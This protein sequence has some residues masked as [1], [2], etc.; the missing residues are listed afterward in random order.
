MWKC[1]PYFGGINFLTRQ[2]L[3]R[4]ISGPQYERQGG[5]VAEKENPG[6]S[7][8]TTDEVGG[9]V[10]GVRVTLNRRLFIQFLAFGGCS[11]TGVLLNQFESSDIPAA[12]YED[13]N[14]SGGIGIVVVFEDP[15]HFLTRL[16]PFLAR[17]EFKDLLPKP[18]LTMFGRTYAVG[19]EK[20]LE[21]SLLRKPLER[22]GSPDSR[23][24]IWY[25]LRRKG[26]YERLTDHEQHEIQM[27]HMRVARSYG[28][29]GYVSDI[30]LACHGLGKQDNDFIV[31]LLG[32]EL[33]PLSMIIQEMRKSRQTSAYLER[34]GPF[35][36]GRTVGYYFPDIGNNQ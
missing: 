20:N 4:N 19:Y 7:Q 29:K 16:R 36:V 28:R 32:S 26:K 24:A 25:P 35:F 27:E 13:I 8:I 21:Y 18:E 11:D 23:W 5:A 3:G 2:I 14:D 31:G 12:V 17:P 34:L 22:L 10:E 6:E 1:R 30:R 33:H 15:E 9:E